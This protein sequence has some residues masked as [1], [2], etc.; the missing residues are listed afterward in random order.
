MD[1]PDFASGTGPPHVGLFLLALD[2]AAFA[3]DYLQRVEGHFQRLRVRYG[4]D[5]GRYLPHVQRMQL[6]DHVYDR[7]TASARHHHTPEGD[8]HACAG[9]AG[10][11]T[12]CRV[13]A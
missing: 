5:F 12:H 3:P 11:A 13:L 7:L 8:I 9:A 2:P 1:A 10:T 4:I 6:A